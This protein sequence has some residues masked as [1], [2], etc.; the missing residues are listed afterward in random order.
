MNSLHR[1]QRKTTTLSWICIF[2]SST[3]V[4]SQ[5]LE[6][7]RVAEY[8]RRGYSWPP[9]ESEFVP[10]TPG[11]MKLL[12]NRLGQVD[13]LTAGGDDDV[14]NAYLLTLS[15]VLAHNYTKY[16]FGI[17]KSPSSAFQLLQDFVRTS[18]GDLNSTTLSSLPIE[19]PDETAVDT[20]EEYQVMDDQNE[21]VTTHRPKFLDLP[22]SIGAQIMKEIQ[23]IM[24]AWAGGIALE[25]V[26]AYG[27]RIYQNTS[28]LYMHLDHRMT[29][30]ISAILHI[31][32][33]T[34]KP[35]PLVIED[36]SGITNEVHL[37]PGDMLLYESSKCWHGR[38]RRMDGKWYSS[39]FIH[40][41]P[42]FAPTSPD[43]SFTEYIND[44][45]WTVQY[46]VPP[47]WLVRHETSINSNLATLVMPETCGYEPDCEDGWCSLKD[48]VV[49]K[50]AAPQ[51]YGKVLTAN[52]EIYDLNTHQYQSDEL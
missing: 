18:V 45:E 11:W 23:P 29:H 6:V 49:V 26:A 40:F 10:A 43:V 46:R 35:W 14:Y 38:P 44:F 8:H 34:A 15:S 20:I 9:L 13:L 4:H 24:E 1:R 2:L 51:E 27:L 31:G 25:P 12:Q 32:H 30:V 21:V 5:P 37:Y 3:V 7:D 47:H 41:R 33:D 50:D 52:G 39:L 19:E 42:K 48:S 36:F 17:T 16:G 28:Q 22:K